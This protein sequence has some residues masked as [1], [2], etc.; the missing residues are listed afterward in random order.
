MKR[1]ATHKRRGHA[2]GAL[3]KIR[4]YRGMTIEITREG[5]WVEANIYRHDGRLEEHLGSGTYGPGVYDGFFRRGE[6][7]I[8]AM[9]GD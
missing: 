8:D 9:K 1:R 5:S 6:R 4:G 7:V 2:S 3:R